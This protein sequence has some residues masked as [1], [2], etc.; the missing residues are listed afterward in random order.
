MDLQ[1]AHDIISICKADCGGATVEDCAEKLGIS[2]SRLA[3]VFDTFDEL[4]RSEKLMRIAGDRYVPTTQPQEITG[5]YKGYTPTFG[6]VLSQDLTEDVYIA[7]QNRNTA[8]NNDKVTVRILHSGDGRHK[9]EGEIIAIVERANKTLVGT[10][11]REKHSAF[12]TPD[13]ERIREDVYIPLD[14]TGGARS[15]ARVQVKITKWPEKDRKAEGEVTEVL[16]YDGDKDLDIKVI[17]ARHDLPFDFPDDVKKEAEKIDTTV[18]MEEGRRDYRDRQ[19]I[20]IDSEDAKDLTM[21]STSYACRTAISASAST[22]PTSATT[23]ALI[24]PSTRKR[25]TAAR[26]STSSTASSPCCR[27]S[28]RTVSAASTPVK[29]A[30]L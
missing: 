11:Q 1:L 30:I 8:M 5:I 26:A 14:K 22:S 21:P 7:E 13:D 2:G 24:R 12:V 19:L 17:M 16:G 23:S 3:D 18:V 4:V 20:T 27:R 6:F 9:Q 25:T 10:F 28:S 15:S 29:T